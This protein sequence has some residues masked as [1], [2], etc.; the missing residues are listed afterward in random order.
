MAL[1]GQVLGSIYYWEIR[2]RNFGR[3]MRIDDGTN[4]RVQLIATGT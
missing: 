1:S 4:Q 3:V 2:D